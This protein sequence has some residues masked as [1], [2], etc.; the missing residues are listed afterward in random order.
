MK[1]GCTVWAFAKQHYAAPYEEAIHAIGKLGFKALD[2]MI[3]SQQ[4]MEEYWTTQQIKEIRELY[5][6]Y[7]LELTQLHVFDHVVNGLSS[8]DTTRKQGSLAAFNQC[9]KIGKELGAPQMQMVSHWI[10]GL[11]GPTAYPPHVTYVEVRNSPTFNPKL[12]LE[13]PS[14]LDWE[15]VWDNYVD[16]IRQCNEIAKSYGM[17]F[18]LE[19]HANVIVPGTDGLL[20]LLEQ[21]AHENFGDNFDT[22][23]HLIQREYLPLSVHKLKDK[24]FGIHARDGDALACYSLPPGQGVIDWDEEAGPKPTKRPDLGVQQ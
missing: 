1:V 13:L 5:T 20:R 17:R 11:K 2:L 9:C 7:D 4:D 12:Y 21:I 6:S 22:A 14:D 3:F 10:D 15:A 16:S 19:G 23:W 8:L 18:A 24:I